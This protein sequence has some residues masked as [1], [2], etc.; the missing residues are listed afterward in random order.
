VSSLSPFGAALTAA[1]ELAQLANSEQG[2]GVL[3]RLLATHVPPEKIAQAIA[4]LKDAPPPAASAP[5]E[6]KG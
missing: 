5:A 1:S 4:G 6:P 3:A 2:R